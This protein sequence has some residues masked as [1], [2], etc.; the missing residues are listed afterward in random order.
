MY[1][2]AKVNGDDVIIGLKEGNSEFALL[3]DTITIEVAF[4]EFTKI[5]VACEFCN[6]NYS[7]DEVDAEKLFASCIAHQTP[8]TEQ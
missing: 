2:F 3:S 4:K 1:I 5:E 6:H 8:K 7:F